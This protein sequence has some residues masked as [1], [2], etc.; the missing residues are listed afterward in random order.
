MADPEKT[1]A[2]AVPETTVTVDTTSALAL[3]GMIGSGKAPYWS[4]IRTDTPEGKLL[5]FKVSQE[6]DNTIDDK[7]GHEIL[8]QDVYVTDASKMD[9]KTGE[10]HSFKRVVLV[11]PDGESYGTFSDGIVNSIFTMCGVF[12]LPPWKGGVKVRLAEKKTGS[13]YKMFQ[14]IPVLTGTAKPGTPPRQK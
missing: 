9:H 7:I 12:G 4:S 5:L 14:L 8:L 10:L 2:L 3:A 11:T 1:T 13:G 6:A